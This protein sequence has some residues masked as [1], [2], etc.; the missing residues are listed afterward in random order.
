MPGFSSGQQQPRSSSPESTAQTRRL[1]EKAR[2]A[3]Q[4]QARFAREDEYHLLNFA[5]G[6]VRRWKREGVGQEIE[7]EL[8]AEAQVPMSR[9]SSLFL[10]LL[11]S[12]LPRLAGKRASKMALALAA[13]DDQAL[14]P[15]GWPPFHGTMAGSRVQPAS[16]RRRSGELHRSVG[17]LPLDFAIGW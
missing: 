2:R 3:A 1:F 10:V 4:G 7:R 12:A 8:R 16:A 17:S 15:S 9:M 5:Y 11:R 6:A 13:A 14:R